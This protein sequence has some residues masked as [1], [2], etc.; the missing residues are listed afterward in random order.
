[1]RL[2]R[3]LQVGLWAILLLM[4][5]VLIGVLIF[6]LVR[7]P[8]IEQPRPFQPSKVFVDLL[9]EKGTL[10]VDH[11]RQL[12]GLCVDHEKMIAANNI[13]NAR[14]ASEMRDLFTYL[15]VFLL[16]ALLLQIVAAT[17]SF[18]MPTPKA[19]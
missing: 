4:Q 19:S 3:H 7:Q 16:I 11:Q 10:S 2:Q 17:L 1:M 5:T 8:A 13:F 15:L 14:L 9:S 18:R 6:A 12:I